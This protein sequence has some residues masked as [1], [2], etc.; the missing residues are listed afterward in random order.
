[1]APLGVTEDNN[2][3]LLH[4]D[5]GDWPIVKDTVSKIFDH[6]DKGNIVITYYTIAGEAIMYEDMSVKNKKKRFNKS[7]R[8]LKT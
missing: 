5:E 7:K 1:M 3:I 4:N 6:D 8:K 2:K